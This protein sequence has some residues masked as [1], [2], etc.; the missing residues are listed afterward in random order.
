MHSFLAQV[1]AFDPSAININR[2]PII[3]SLSISAPHSLSH[4]AAVLNFS[5]DYTPFFFYILQLK[6]HYYH[7]FTV[8]LDM[9]VSNC[10]K[11][12]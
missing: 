7:F 6:L 4:S 2:P 11:N 8:F 3:P 10:N 9:H 1:K 5:K 12:H